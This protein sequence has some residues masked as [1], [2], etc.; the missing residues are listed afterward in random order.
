M[1]LLFPEAEVVVG[2]TGSVA[3]LVGPTNKPIPAL[4]TP[5]CN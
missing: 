1:Y 3:L 5:T 2:P 4:V